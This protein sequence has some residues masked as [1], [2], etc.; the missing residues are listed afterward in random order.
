MPGRC[1]GSQLAQFVDSQNR[2]KFKQGKSK[3]FAPSMRK[4]TIS[5]GVEEPQAPVLMLQFVWAYPLRLFSAES[6]T[7]LRVCDR[8]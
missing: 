6:R 2:C 8:Q 4:P 7:S 3:S 5:A 1:S